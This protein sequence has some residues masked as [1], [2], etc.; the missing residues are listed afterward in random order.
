M[1]HYVECHSVFREKI[2]KNVYPYLSGSRLSLLSIKKTWPSISA[3]LFAFRLGCFVP[4]LVWICRVVLEKKNQNMTSFQTYKQKDRQTKYDKKTD[5]WRTILTFQLRW[6]KTLYVFFSSI[7][8][9]L[10]SFFSI[11]RNLFERLWSFV[12]IFY[13][14]ENPLSIGYEI[15]LNF[16]SYKVFN[17][18]VLKYITFNITKTWSVKS[19]SSINLCHFVVKYFNLCNV[20]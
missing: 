4:N 13:P 17:I 7:L 11:P 19:V 20:I 9:H 3:F 6:P 12:S 10:Q 16:S 15:H 1:L 5:R 8:P 2:F 18:S 14:L